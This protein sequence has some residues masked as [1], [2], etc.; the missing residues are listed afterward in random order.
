VTVA[1]VSQSLIAG[2]SATFTAAATGEPAPS[3]TWQRSTD[4]GATWTDDTTD[5]GAGTDSLLVAGATVGE[6]GFKY[7]AV[8][9][10]VVGAV[11]T[12]AATLSVSPVGAPVASFTW[13]PAHPHVGE[14]V[15]LVSTASDADSPIA[16]FAWN[17]TGA[18]ALVPGS[19]VIKTTFATAGAHAVSLG[20]T[21]QRGLA[22]SVTQTIL[23]DP[24]V[25]PLIQPFPVVRIAG[26]DTTVGAR[27]TLLTVLAP[28]GA[29]IT[30]TCK[31]GGCPSHLRASQYALTYHHEALALLKFKRFQRAFRAP[32]A[33][34]IRVAARGEIG[35]YT[36]FTIRRGKLPVRV[37]SCLDPTNSKPMPCPGP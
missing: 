29:K 26:F 13:F 23:V 32:A 19:S 16:S 18:G 20:V 4:G 7:R 12:A 1:P 28:A 37:D 21:D 2:Q 25:F 14:T 24:R 8:F 33:L 15:S 9:S 5:A 22:A 36:R 35:K 27:L 31:G 11:E 6:N 17:T 34:E 30:I 10:N 3:E